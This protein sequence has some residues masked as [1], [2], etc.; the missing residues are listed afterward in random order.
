M[1]SVFARLPSLR[2]SFSPNECPQ[3][4]V[5]LVVVVASKERISSADHAVSNCAQSFELR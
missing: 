1:M 2:T 4:V 3:V 5:Q